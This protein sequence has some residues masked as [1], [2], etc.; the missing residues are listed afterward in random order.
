MSDIDAKK[1]RVRPWHSDDVK[2]MTAKELFDRVTIDS[3]SDYGWIASATSLYNTCHQEGFPEK[4]AV[5]IMLLILNCYANLELKKTIPSS[6]ES[7]AQKTVNSIYAELSSR[8]ETIKSIK[9]KYLRNIV[10]AVTEYDMYEERL[11]LDYGESF[12]ELEKQWEEDMFQKYSKYD[13]PNFKKVRAELYREYDK[14]LKYAHLDEKVKQ[15]MEIEKKKR[16]E[17]LAAFLKNMK[18]FK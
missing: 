12:Y 13:A 17:A 2:M 5:G 6:H 9:D 11:K 14:F 4:Y 10:K 3:E 1:F 7:T 18:F 15:E 16:E 8:D